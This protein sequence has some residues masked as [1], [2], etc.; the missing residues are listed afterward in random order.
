MG[1]WLIVT[2]GM[3]LAGGFVLAICS[4]AARPIPKPGDANVE[5]ST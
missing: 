4:A 5:L 3:L 1:I 2:I